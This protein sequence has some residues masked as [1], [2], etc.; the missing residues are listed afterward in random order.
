[1]GKGMFEKIGLMMDCSFNTVPTVKTVKLMIDLLSK[2]GYNRLELYTEDTYE[3]KNRPY[4]GYLRGRYTGA[5][6]KELDAYAISKGIELRPCIQVLAH[7]G[8]LFRTGEF[9]HVKDC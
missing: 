6:L 8:G 9:D 3:I 1:M 4:F 2:M 5:E 7:L